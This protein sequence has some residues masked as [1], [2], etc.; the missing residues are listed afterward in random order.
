M[1]NCISEK[2]DKH[3]YWWRYEH[4]HGEPSETLD[5]AIRVAG[6]VAASEARKRGKSYVVASQPQPA[7]VYVF[8][9]DHPD[10]RALA[11][12]VMLTFAPD[13]GCVRH[14]PATAH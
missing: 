12:S 7:R 4:K 3:G 8:A 2:T 5:M 14:Q 10:A 11:I 9:E 13:G 6:E 1:S